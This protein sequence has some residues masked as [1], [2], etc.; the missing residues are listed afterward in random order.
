MSNTKISELT[1][2]TPLE[3]DVIPYVDL[4][5]GQTKKAIKS[6]L[7]GNTGTTGTAATIYVGT[8][9]TGNPGTEA[10]VTNVGTASVATFNFT[11]PRGDVGPTGATGPTG[12]A[13]SGNVTG[14]ASSMG[15]N[16]AVFVGTTGTTIADGGIGIAQI[17]TV[18][19]VNSKVTQTIT[20]GVTTTAPSEDAVFDAL[21]LKASLTGAETLT[22]KR[23]QQRV[24][25]TTSSN[26]LVINK[27]VYDAY[28]LTAQAAN[29]TISSASTATLTGFEK[30][31]IQ[32][33]GNGSS[34]WTIG[35]SGDFVAKAGVTL[36]TGLTGTKN[37]ELG[38]EWNANLGKYNLLAKG[39]ES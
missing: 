5:S 22:N 24:Y 32:L 2:G 19:F 4:S 3:T 26:T 25:S 11:I 20:N 14:P 31:Q 30:V 10:S 34:N 39:E 29:T 18:T 37:M 23:V 38:F 36:P 35:F 12:P 8:T 27:T 17:A 6:E 7:K 13:G 28:A 9:T 33:L 15:S 1:Q 16:I 21:A